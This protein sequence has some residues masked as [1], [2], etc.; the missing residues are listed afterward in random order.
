MMP[1]NGLSIS[2]DQKKRTDADAMQTIRTTMT[3]RL[4]GARRP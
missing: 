4:R 1:S 2:E 3:V